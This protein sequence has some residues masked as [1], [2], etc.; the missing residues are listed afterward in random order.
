M[1]EYCKVCG[2]ELLTHE[3][4]KEGICSDCKREYNIIDSD[5]DCVIDE[6]DD[7]FD[8]PYSTSWDNW[9]IY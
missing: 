9:D 5:D 2:I 3:E 1:L 7:P 6:D 4:L 8:H